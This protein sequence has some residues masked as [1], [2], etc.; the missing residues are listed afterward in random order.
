M[1]GLFIYTMLDFQGTLAAKEHREKAVTTAERER[2]C[3]FYHAQ[4]V[5]PKSSQEETLNEENNIHEIFYDIKSIHSLKNLI[6]CEF[7]FLKEYK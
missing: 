6:N 4:D 5:R 7:L 2:H 1:L 3:A